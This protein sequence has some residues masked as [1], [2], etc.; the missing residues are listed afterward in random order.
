MI[1]KEDLLKVASLAKLYVSDKECD[2]LLLDMEHIVSFAKVIENASCENENI[3]SHA[4]T[5]TVFRKDE[6]KSSL[7]AEEV[8]RNAPESR[9][10]FFVVRK[11]RA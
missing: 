3:T 6:A 4:D 7:S 5:E 10:G 8:L 11:G 9:D 1:E 2:A